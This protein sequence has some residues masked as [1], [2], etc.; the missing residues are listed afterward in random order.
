[1]YFFCSEFKEIFHKVKYEKQEINLSTIQ[2][3]IIK[4]TQKKQQHFFFGKILGIHLV[5]GIFK[6]SQTI[7]TWQFLVVKQ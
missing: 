4:I 6:I 1:M 5:K 3:Y 7:I 2:K